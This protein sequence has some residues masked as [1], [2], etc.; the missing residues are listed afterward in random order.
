MRKK[1]AL[2]L[3]MTGGLQ[4]AMTPWAGVAPLIETMRQIEMVEKADKVLPDELRLLKAAALPKEYA[5]AEPKRLRFT[6][7]TGLGQVV[8]HARLVVMKVLEGIWNRLIRAALERAMA[9]SPLAC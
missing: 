8:S 7:F 1:S 3:A 2:G 5:D 4:V 6:V 9:L